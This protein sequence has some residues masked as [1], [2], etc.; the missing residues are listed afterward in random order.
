LMTVG[1]GLDFPRAIEEG[2]LALTGCH[3]W[4]LQGV[5]EYLWEER[6]NLDGNALRNAVRQ[7]FRS[8]DGIFKSWT[9]SL[10]LSGTAVYEAL[11]NA[12]RHE[13]RRDQLRPLVSR[14]ATISGALDVLGYHGLID[15]I[16]GDRIKLNGT[17]FRDWFTQN[18]PY[19]NFYE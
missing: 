10:G 16:E 14:D 4:L 2:L 1:F 5:L 18:R 13:V 12:D 11:V 6:A 8:R 3:P 19:L 7:F 9:K 17:I 15:E